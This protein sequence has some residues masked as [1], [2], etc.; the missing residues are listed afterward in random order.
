MNITFS[1]T[2][3]KLIFYLLT[4]IILFFSVNLK[5]QN[6]DS[7]ENILPFKKGIEKAKLLNE[8]ANLYKINSFNRSYQ[9]ANQAFVLATTLS[10]NKEQA[11]AT[12]TLGVIYYM[13]G[14]NQKALYY[15]E[16]TIRYRKADNDQIGLA[17]IL[18]NIGLIY[19]NIG[20]YNKAIEY[21]N[22]ALLLHTQLKNK[23]GLANVTENIGVVYDNKGDYEKA[24]EYYQKSLK[25]E[26]EL[27]NKLGVSQSLNSIA[28][29]FSKMNNY[30]KALDYYQQSL[31]IKENLGDKNEVAITLNNIGVV[32]RNIKN[33]SKAIEYF[34][35]SLEFAT[36]SKNM[37]SIANTLNNL[38]EIYITKNNQDKALSY[39]KQSLVINQKMGNKTG[40]ASCYLHFANIYKQNNNLQLAINYSIQSIT[41]A[42]EIGLKEIISK[43]YQLQSEIY[44]KL[45]DFEKA[46]L[47]Q[48]NYITIK[49]SMINETNHKQ[50]TEIETKY[51]TEKKQ[52]EILFLNQQSELN[53]LKIKKNEKEIQFQRIINYII[54]IGFVLILF[55]ALLLYK[56][57][58]DKKT[59]NLKLEIQNKEIN[60]QKEEVEIQK[61]IAIQQ[62]DQ[63][64]EQKKHITDSILYAQ[65]IQNAI[66]PHSKC[67]QNFFCNNFIF[68]KPKDIVS[69]D[70]YWFS[71]AAKD[72]NKIII[73]A[74]DCTGHG[75][76]GAFMS[77]VAYNLLKQA[78]N[79]QKLSNPATILNALSETL[80]NT[81][82]LSDDENI[83]M[84]SMDISIC[85]IN[86]Q[87]YQL[88]YSGANNPIYIIRNRELIEL[89][90]DKHS[91]G[92]SFTENFI[93]FKNNKYQLQNNDTIYMFSDGYVDQ[94]GG[95]NRKKFL[96]R[97]FKKYLIELQDFTMQQQKE[98]LE[99]TLTDWQGNIEQYDDI[100]VIGLKINKKSSNM[101][102]K[103]LLSYK[104]IYHFETIEKLIN[105]AKEAIN[106]IDSK[107]I[108]K[109]KIINILI[110]CLENIHKYAII[111]NENADVLPQIHLLKNEDSFKIITK[112]LIAI[113][114]AEILT[115]HINIVNSLDKDGL[116]KLYEEIINNGS[117]SDK[118][119]AGLGF[120]D[121]AI[122]SGNQINYK[123][124]NN[125]TETTFFELTIVINDITI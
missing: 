64:T 67:I 39:F 13:K 73:A 47:N 120:V 29:I 81:L 25:I 123:F 62:R 88:E 26:E 82:Q 113:K 33:D 60:F 19:I 124:T 71:S 72:T 63:I 37:Q 58:I 98:K 99:K 32:L 97:Q 111:D 110:E 107:N 8:L 38:G 106:E 3:K 46:Y 20:N 61:N 114:Q 41:L 90:A 84:D 105:Q 119:G 54:L 11:N 89:K 22:N 122:K 48:S 100:M 6:I 74:I 40:I 94:F 5:A 70:F 53:E 104:G 115:K 9:Y 95:P 76:P 79:E 17:N 34:E 59:V 78:I 56:Q 1:F 16:K 101:E 50:I 112:N 125:N 102:E 44:A 87:T 49:D 117:I 75:V 66:L 83:I 30:E 96:S 116:K 18:S 15:W 28:G 36:A 45:N 85:V 121:M 77:I 21:F 80:Y 14:D 31:K 52:K 92:E 4:I 108:V 42:K 51:Q 35:K 109:K 57:Y 12:Y 10:N 43:N 7:L 118:G 24:I 93:G 68:Y 103:I 65:K 27:E 55:I 91:I 2:Y 86:K 69:G 23:K